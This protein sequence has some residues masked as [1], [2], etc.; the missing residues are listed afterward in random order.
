MFSSYQTKSRAEKLGGHILEAFETVLGSP[1]TIEIRCESKKASASGVHV[2]L[3]LPASEVSLSQIRDINRVSTQAQLLQSDNS[4]MGSE[5]VEVAA[6]PRGPKGNEHIHNL[7]ASDN[8]GLGGS[9][10]G[11]ATMASAPGSRKF[12]EQSQSQSLVR[13]KVSLA[14]VIQQAE[15]C[16][17]RRGWSKRKAVS[18]AEKL[19]QE[20]LRLEPRSRSLLCWKATRV[21]RRKLSR[22]KIRTQKPHSL[23]KLV[24]CGKCLS[25]KSP[26]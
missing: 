6:S 18:I 24:S 13:S 17:Q 7:V 1:V 19:E 23:L 3:M 9:C 11:E 10:V 22:L 15:G 2:P 20:N 5:I 25:T 16:S 26:R 8:R 12:G 4:K 14:H 21:T